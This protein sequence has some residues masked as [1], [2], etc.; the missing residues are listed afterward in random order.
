M[1]K[2]DK[3]TI[4]QRVSELERLIINGGLPADAFQYSIAKGWGV[5]RRQVRRYWSQAYDR[6]V[7]AL[8]KDHKRLFGKHLSQR[9]V[10]HMK[11]LKEGDLR[12]A[13]RVLQDEAKL[14]GL[15]ENGKSRV[16]T[17]GDTQVGRGVGA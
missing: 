5:S 2:A 4:R 15:Y 8:E 3:K 1:A 16:A 11:C 10:L 9:S 12:G 6:I 14:L 17:G 13:L 7:D